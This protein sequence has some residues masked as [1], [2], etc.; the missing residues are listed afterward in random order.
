MVPLESGQTI[1]VAVDVMH[2]VV[3]TAIAEVLVAESE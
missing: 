1:G 2:G 3:E